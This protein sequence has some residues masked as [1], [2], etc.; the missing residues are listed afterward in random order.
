METLTRVMARHV[1]QLDL[2]NL[3]LDQL[4][5]GRTRK[6]RQGRVNMKP[7]PQPSGN[8]GN[9]SFSRSWSRYET[10]NQEERK[11]ALRARRATVVAG[12]RRKE[13]NKIFYKINHSLSS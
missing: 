13:G 11:E 8:T 7:V 2:N 10:G 3:P 6:R 1:Y 12:N 9:K 5:D 4:S